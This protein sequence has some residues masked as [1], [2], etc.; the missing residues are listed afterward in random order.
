M[1]L[2]AFSFGGENYDIQ[3]Q[4]HVNKFWRCVFA[5][6]ADIQIQA[7]VNRELMHSLLRWA[8][9][10]KMSP[11]QNWFGS[12]KLNNNKFLYC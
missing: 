5:I 8:F 4:W 1:V 11:R 2:L 9:I 12:G 6:L 7:S 10:L 3:W